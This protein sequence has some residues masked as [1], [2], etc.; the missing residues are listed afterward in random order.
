MPDDE[1]EMITDAVV[2]AELREHY[3]EWVI[4][5]CFHHGDRGLLVQQPTGQ[6]FIVTA[7][8]VTGVVVT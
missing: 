4:R 8:E 2:L 1:P 5:D 7:H 3:G 6:V